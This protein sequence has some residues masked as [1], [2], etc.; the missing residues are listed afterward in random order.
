VIVG[1][2]F[3]S[4]VWLRT[5]FRFIRNSLLFGLCHV[6]FLVL[7]SQS[8]NMAI[9]VQMINTHKWSNSRHLWKCLNRVLTGRVLGNQNVHFIFGCGN[10]WNSGL[11][12]GERE[13]DDNK[14]WTTQMLS[15]LTLDIY[16]MN[17]M[18]MLADNSVLP[19]ICISH[20]VSRNTTDDYRCSS[21]CN[22]D[23]CKDEVVAA[24]E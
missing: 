4:G 3:G 8:H 24:V 16:D 18:T 21:S 2:G 12:W 22:A 13:S 11:T 7:R 6:L 14:S 17:C 15:S 19:W 9:L 10:L 5:H 23:C 20:L 1:L